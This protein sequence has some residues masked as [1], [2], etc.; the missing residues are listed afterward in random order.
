MKQS[1][2][3]A[4]EQRLREFPPERKSDR[5]L[6]A[7]KI[8]TAKVLAKVGYEDLRVADISKEAGLGTATFHDYFDNR[9]HAAKEVLAGFVD[10]ILSTRAE[11]HGYSSPFA[12]IYF[13]NK[14]L[15]DTYQA[16]AGLMKSLIQ[17]WNSDEEFSMLWR[18]V[19]SNWY[20]IV[21]NVM[22]KRHLIEADKQFLFMS[23]YTVGGMLDQFMLGLYVY[24]DA[25]ILDILKEHN[26]GDD[27]LAYF[28]S[29]LWYRSLFGKDPHEIPSEIDPKIVA[30]FREKLNILGS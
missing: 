17:L 13:I 5:T 24:K 12:S 30:V 21:S 6:A 2:C 11:P 25:S 15:I 26:L 8:A 20:D 16:N 4:L 29:I 7:L 28:L 1:Y 19:S 9:T 10:T 14:E 18:R 23:I 27:A 22:I 3:D